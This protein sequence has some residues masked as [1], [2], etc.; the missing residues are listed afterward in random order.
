MRSTSPHRLELRERG[1]DVASLSTPKELINTCVLRWEG[2]GG[3]H[4]DGDPAEEEAPDEGA[5][6]IDLTELLAR[7]LK[8][9]KSAKAPARSASEQ[10][11][12]TK[13]Q[14][15]RKAAAKKVTPVV[16]SS[17]RMPRVCGQG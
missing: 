3:R 12:E 14:P 1:G 5:Q 10:K 6:V 13:Q 2:E 11:D 4:R 17:V 16:G 7:S 15:A 8:S 9:G